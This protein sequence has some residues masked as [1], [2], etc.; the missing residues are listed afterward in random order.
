MRWLAV[1]LILVG[2]LLIQARP[3]LGQPPQP[4][5]RVCDEARTV[6]LGNMARRQNGVPPLRWNW[7]LTTAARWFS[8]DS[9][10]NRPTPYCGHQ[11]TN[12]NW[13]DYRARA[14]GYKGS[15]GA[16]NCFCGYVTPE[17]AIAGWMNSPGHRANLLDPNSHEIG[18]G[19]YLRESDSRGYVTQDFGHDTIYP[20]VIIENEAISTTSPSVNLYVYS[21]SGGGFAGIGPAVQMMVSNDP[22]FTNATWEPYTAEKPW[23]L[24]PGE[25]WRTVY[26]KSRDALSRT[27]VVSDAIYLGQ[28][29]PL[30]DL[31]PAQMSTTQEQVTIYNLQVGGWPLVQF[32]PGWVA[33]DTFGTFTLWWGNGERVNDTTA[34]GSTAFRLWPGNGESFAWVWTTEFFKDIPLMAYFRLKVNDNTSGSE[35]ARISVKGGGHEYGPLSLKG[36][37]FTAANR[38]QEFPMAFTFHTN[39]D[40]PFL[41]F[42]FWRSGSADVYV[43]AVSIFSAPQPVAS[44]MTWTM[45]GGNYR[46]QGIWLRYTNGSGQFSSITEADILFGGCLPSTPTPTATSTLTPTRTSIPT[47]TPTPT[48]TRTPTPSPTR[49]SLQK[50]LYLPIL[51]KNYA[52]GEQPPT[53]TPTPFGGG[54]RIAFESSRDGQ[55]EI[56]VINPDGT[57]LT[58]ITNNPA[59]DGHPGWSPDG[60][61]IV[62]ASNRDNNWDVYVMNADGSSVTRLTTD[63]AYDGEPVWSPDGR[64]IAFHSDRDGQGEI[65]RMRTDGTELTN[66]TRSPFWDFGP[67]WSPD[68]NRM[69]FVSCRGGQ[70]LIYTMNSDGSG[71]TCLICGTFISSGGQPSWSPDGRRIAFHGTYTGRNDIYVI[72]VDGTGITN[73]TNHPDEDVEPSWSPDGQWIVFSSNRDGNWNIYRIRPDGTGLTQITNHPADD[74][75]PAWSSR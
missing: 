58:R 63:P 7:Q 32:S 18:L 34:W 71:A 73:V 40:D 30:P 17:Q 13:P 26:V 2:L 14:F 43:D 25:G 3:G 49:A 50:L 47:A 42:N 4:P 53:P 70:C 16:E 59:F 65:Y 66:L 57:G 60:R 29:V 39:A 37:D 56:Y 72:N 41:I 23:M 24:Q 6:Y 64:Y 45:P 22:C 54:G 12:G 20:P 28:N 62:F 55:S 21:E 1:P 35:M 75:N 46:G 9:V 68:G 74:I 27:I 44:V 51:L 10:E 31:G 15:A 11:D 5:A 33:D 69:A 48:R 52:Y 36:T 38:Y 67:W 61:R 19:Y 8:W